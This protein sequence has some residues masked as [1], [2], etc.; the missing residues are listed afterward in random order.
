MYR[1]MKKTFRVLRTVKQ[2]FHANSRFWVLVVI[3]RQ[4]GLYS[5]IPLLFGVLPIF[6]LYSYVPLGSSRFHYLIHNKRVRLGEP[7]SVLQHVTPD[8]QLKF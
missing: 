3:V 6:R 2:D 4:K 5:S 7:C 8:R 1:L